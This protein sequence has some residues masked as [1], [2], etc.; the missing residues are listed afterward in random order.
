MLYYFVLLLYDDYIWI[1]LHF[2]CMSEKYMLRAIM[3]FCIIDYLSIIFVPNILFFYFT[4][5]VIIATPG[6]ILDLLDKSIAKVDH[7]R[8]L[9]LDEVSNLIYQFVFQ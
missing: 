8:I 6:R 5:H 1:P 7:C 4:V 9:V 3:F 2:K